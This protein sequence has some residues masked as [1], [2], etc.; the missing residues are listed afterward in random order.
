MIAN[1]TGGYLK[2]RSN[3]SG[4]MEYILNTSHL[5]NSRTDPL[6]GSR[7]RSLRGGRIVSG[8][9][10]SNK[11]NCTAPQNTRNHNVDLH[12]KR[13]FNGPPIIGA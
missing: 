7:T 2:S 5:V 6:V 9:K 3:L 8:K 11:R 13:V 1:I 12:P 10:R 4:P